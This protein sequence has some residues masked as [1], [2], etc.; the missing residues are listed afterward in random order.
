MTSCPVVTLLRGLRIECN[1]LII[2][3]TAFWFLP[4]LNNFTSSLDCAAKGH[5]ECYYGLRRWLSF[6][7]HFVDDV[8]AT[9]H[10]TAQLFSCVYNVKTRRLMV[11]SFILRGKQ[12]KGQSHKDSRFL[13]LCDL[14]RCWSALPSSSRKKFNKC[15]PRTEHCSLDIDL[16]CL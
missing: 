15:T 3:M 10:Y 8:C 9:R 5:F 11:P 14:A 2:C 6:D 16:L 7:W 12:N 13:S 1:C 4:P